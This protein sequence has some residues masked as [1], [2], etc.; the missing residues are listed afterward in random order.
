MT[1]VHRVGAYDPPS[2]DD[3]YASTRAADRADSRAV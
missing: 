2:M 3:L 1:E